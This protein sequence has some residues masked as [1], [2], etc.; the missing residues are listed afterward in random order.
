MRASFSPD[1]KK[2][3]Y[4]PVAE[5][6]TQWKN[7][8][9]GTVSRIWIYD[10]GDHSVQQIRQP[11]G[12]S[13]DTDPVFVGERVYFRSDRN[14]EFNLFS[15]DPATEAVEQLTQHNDFPINRLTESKDTIIYEQGGYLH[16]F[17]PQTKKSSRLE[18]SVTTDATE[19]RPRF[20]SG[21]NW[22]RGAAVSPSGARAAF[23]FRGEI[24]TVPAKKGDV[25]NLTNTTGVHERSPA[26]SP[27]GKWIAYFSDAGGE[28]RLHI[29]PQDG[30]GRG[31]AVCARGTRLLS[32]AKMVA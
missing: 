12:R 24:V 10:T 29:A 21:S 6:F 18:I 8:R 13:N 26:W 19:L 20:V 15:F 16:L 3:A 9:G 23:E 1:G 11:E 30:K 25:R 7:Y 27:N 2:I 31:E 17:D 32:P 22:I 4:I 5:R 28:Y 14:G